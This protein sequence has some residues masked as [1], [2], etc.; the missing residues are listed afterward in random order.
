M[1]GLAPNSSFSQ[2]RPPSAS[3]TA[4]SFPS[5]SRTHAAPQ[6]YPQQYPTVQR[7]VPGRSTNASGFA[8]EY[9]PVQR[10]MP[11][12]SGNC[13]SFIQNYISQAHCANA[14]MLSSQQRRYSKN[15]SRQNHNMASSLAQ[16]VLLSS[17]NNSQKCCNHNRR[18]SHDNS[19]TAEDRVTVGLV[20]GAVA[21]ACTSFLSA[22]VDDQKRAEE[23]LKRVNDCE[24]RLNSPEFQKHPHR[25]SLLEI[26]KCEKNIFTHIKNSAI[27]TKALCFSAIASGCFLLLGA[28][29]AS[30]GSL[31]GPA[32]ITV[33]FSG[34]VATAA[35]ALFIAIRNALKG[36]QTLLETEALQ[37]R[38][39]S[40]GNSSS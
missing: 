19:V 1:F 13:S 39:N 40:W 17:L 20:G 4:F 30:P 24:S 15:H 29:L 26:A 32:F 27:E 34:L 8:Q 6:V 2:P 31:L 33:G 16:T 37:N 18:C 5:G 3:G 22:A 36:N 9:P 35:A 38:L 7:E 12:S 21:A 10:E 23:G 28:V 25:Q 11:G 14:Q